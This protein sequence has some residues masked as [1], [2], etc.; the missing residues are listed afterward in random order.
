MWSVLT[1]SPTFRYIII[2]LFWYYLL[3]NTELSPRYVRA[4]CLWKVISRYPI[5]LSL[6]LFLFFLPA[7]PCL[8][9]KLGS[10]GIQFRFAFKCFF[11]HTQSLQCSSYLH[12]FTFAS[13]LKN[14]FAVCLCTCAIELFNSS[15]SSAISRL[16]WL[17]S[18]YLFYNIA[19]AKLNLRATFQ[20]LEHARVRD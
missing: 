9:L 4:G 18:I 5:S 12:H 2:T 8:D 10:F 17:V 16:V 20:Q 11:A 19:R 3:L 1:G 7:L 14:L 13:L 6:S 15:A